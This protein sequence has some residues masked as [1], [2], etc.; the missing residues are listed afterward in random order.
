MVKT[1]T[2]SLDIK[3]VTQKLDHHT[4]SIRKQQDL[5]VNLKKPAA[6]PLE[7]RIKN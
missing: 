2:T 3:L 7:S 4:S 6:C 1:K 5:S